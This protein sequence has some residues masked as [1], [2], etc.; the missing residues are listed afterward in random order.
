MKILVSNP[1]LQYT[2]NTVN[3]LLSAGHDVIF[4]TAYWYQPNRLFEKICAT[5]FTPFNYKLLRYTDSNIPAASIRT[6]F[7][8]TFLHFINKI[9]H[10][11]V[12]QKSFWEDQVH[13]KWVSKL[14]VQLKPELVIGYEKSCY[15]T[16]NSATTI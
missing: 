14:I 10:F 6:S 9:L 1:S 8:G 12:E 4:A 7:F 11:S 2:R 13:D 5:L 16:F 3:A 15:C